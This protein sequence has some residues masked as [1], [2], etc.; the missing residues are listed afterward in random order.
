MAASTP[1]SLRE[2][3]VH[4]QLALGE[5]NRTFGPMLGSSQRTA[6]RWS[7]G[8]SSPSRSQY[9]T[10]VGLVYPKD[11]ALA[12]ELAAALHETLESLG[13]VA[14]KPPSPA[15]P[16]CTH[17]ISELADAVVC[18]AAESIDLSPRLLRTALRAAFTR[19]RALALTV[20]QMEQALAADR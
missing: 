20:E 3:F 15:L 12:A 7:A 18:A 16:P 11:A 13:V 8:R 6:E 10:L 17:A 1:R 19:A 2:L 14:P 4:A 9:V 5:P